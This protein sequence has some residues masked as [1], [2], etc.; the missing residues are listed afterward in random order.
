MLL[1]ELSNL[2]FDTFLSFCVKSSHGIVY[3]SSAL[4]CRLLMLALLLMLFRNPGPIALS[5]WIPVSPCENGN[6]ASFCQHRL[7][8]L[9]NVT[10]PLGK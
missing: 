7:Q 8:S 6:I 3:F 4:E 9:F 2:S 5:L 1:P 10:S